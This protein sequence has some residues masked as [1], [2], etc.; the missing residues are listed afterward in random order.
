MTSKIAYTRSDTHKVSHPRWKR[1][2]LWP[3]T[4]RTAF[5]RCVYTSR[6]N[7]AK[8]REKKLLPNPIGRG[9]ER[10][11]EKRWAHG[12]NGRPLFFLLTTRGVY[13]VHPYPRGRHWDRDNDELPSRKGFFP[14]FFDGIHRWTSEGS[15]HKYIASCCAPEKNS[16]W[17]FSS[18]VWIDSTFYFCNSGDFIFY[19]IYF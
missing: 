4:N 5:G 13:V 18:F 6:G 7:P 12:A 14:P 16:V 10:E 19:S 1:V 2:E 9:G 11:R 3:T 17:C 15:A 8:G